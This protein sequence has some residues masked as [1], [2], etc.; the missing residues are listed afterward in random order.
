MATLTVYD[1]SGRVVC[2][3]A[4]YCR[5]EKTGFLPRPLCLPAGTY[6]VVGAYLDRTG[7]AGF[8][9]DAFETATPAGAEP[10]KVELE[11]R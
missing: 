4:A 11:L 8:A 6:R 9:V 5:D 3:R 2:E 7:E 1:A 10:P